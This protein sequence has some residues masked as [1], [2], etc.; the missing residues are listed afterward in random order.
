MHIATGLMMAFVSRSSSG[1]VRSAVYQQR[2]SSS[3]SSSSRRRFGLAAT[4]VA[5]EPQPPRNPIGAASNVLVVGASRGIGTEFVKQVLGKGASVVATHRSAAVPALLEELKAAHSERLSTLELD[6]SDPESIG[7]AARNLETRG[8]PLTH[9]IHNAGVYGQQ[10][11][12]AGQAWGSRPAAAPV[13]RDIMLDVFATNAVGPLLV[14]QSFYPL[15]AAAG[16]GDGGAE[17]SS[18]SPVIAFLTSKV[19]SIVDNGSGGAYAYRASKIAL[20]MIAKSLSVDLQGK[21]SVVLLHPGYVRTD[22]TGG[23]GLIDVDESV[24]GML[25]A[26]EATDASTDLRWVDYKAELIPW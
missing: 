2:S 16:G 1:L 15:L 6:V 5:K 24:A 26:I 8:P 17:D 21:A 11:S 25:R 7:D 3:S 22:M 23:N 13:T 20:N 10:V 18:S 4:A 19:G 14:A 9:I 12:I